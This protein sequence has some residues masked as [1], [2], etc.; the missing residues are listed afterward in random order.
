MKLLCENAM[1]EISGEEKDVIILLGNI[2][3]N[4]TENRFKAICEFGIGIKNFDIGFSGQLFVKCP[5]SKQKQL[6]EAFPIVDGS[7]YW[8]STHKWEGAII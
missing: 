6:F 5:K 3:D 7:G 1:N 2:K 4:K 8:Q